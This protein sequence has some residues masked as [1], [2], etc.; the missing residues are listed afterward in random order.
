[1]TGHAIGDHATEFLDAAE[2]MRIEDT[3]WWSVGRRTI[4]R[5]YLE[6]AR[7]EAPLTR[8]AEIG[9]GSGGNLR[10]L[11]EYGEVTGVERSAILAERARS[12]GA[13]KEVYLGDFFDLDLR[14]DFQMTCL[15][16][17]LE[18]IEDDDAFLTRLNRTVGPGHLLLLSVPACPF[19]FGPHDRLL[20]HYRRYSKRRLEDLLRRNGYTILKGSH[21]LFFVFPIAVWS[22]LM[23]RLR[24]RWGRAPTA[25]QLG[26]VPARTNAVLTAVLRVE[27]ALAQV[28]PLP[29]GLWFIVLAKRAPAA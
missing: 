22:R 4:L 7:R 27:A 6:R 16:D 5:T 25:V 26:V 2:A 29:V 12:R 28:V 23:E 20:H 9:C 8:I 17:V 24:A 18:H 13:A 15:F 1:M 19:L 10:L 21:F 11:A 14:G 3:V